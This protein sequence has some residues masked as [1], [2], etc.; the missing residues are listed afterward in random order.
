MTLPLPNGAKLPQVI[1]ELNA[2]GVRVAEIEAKIANQATKNEFYDTRLDSIAAEL[3]E[4]QSHWADIH[5]RI[6]VLEE[7]VDRLTPCP[8]ETSE[9]VPPDSDPPPDPPDPPPDP[10][11]EP[12]LFLLAEPS[13]GLSFSALT[14]FIPAAKIVLLYKSGT[15]TLETPTVVGI[16]DTDSII[17]S[18]T[19]TA[20]DEDSWHLTVQLDSKAVGSYNANISVAS[21]NQ[22]N[23]TVEVPITFTVDPAPPVDPPEEEE[24]LH[25]LAEPTS[26][27]FSGQEGQPAPANKIVLL[28][29]NGTGTL[30]T[31]QVIGITDPGGVIAGTVIS[32][33]DADSWHLTVSMK[34]TT[35]ATYNA[36]ITVQS[37]NQT[38]DP[39]VIPVTYVVAAPATTPL[40]LQ[41]STELLPITI[42]E[43]T[44][45]S[46]QT[47]GLA[48]G[49]DGALATPTASAPSESW[50]TGV[51]I[52]GSWPNWSAQLTFDTDALAD[53]LHSAT[54]DFQSA[55]ATNNPQTLTVQ[56][57][58]TNVASPGVFPYGA[59]ALPNGMLFDY[60]ENGVRLVTGSPL[61][62]SH[63]A[64][65]P[66][67]GTIR[68]VANASDWNTKAP[69]CVAGDA[70]RITAD[71][72]T[73]SPLMWNKV[74]PSGFVRVITD[75]L[76]QLDIDVP[77]NGD[78]LN[79]TSLNRI[80]LTDTT[81]YRTITA[82][83]TNAPA[84]RFGQGAC[85]LAI[86]GVQF[87]A[88]ISA[89]EGPI[90]LGTLTASQV[91][92]LPHR[93]ILDRCIGN[94]DEKMKR[95]INMNC[96]DALICGSLGINA[97]SSRPVPGTFSD[98]QGLAAWRGGLQC[99]IF[100]NAFSGESECVAFG[101]S[102]PGITNLIAGTDVALIRNHL[103]KPSSWDSDV[104]YPL[105][106][107]MIEWKGCLRF[108]YMGNVLENYKA[109]NQ[110]QHHQVVIKAETGGETWITTQ[111]LTILGNLYDDGDEGGCYNISAQGSNSL[112]H[113][114]MARITIVH[115]Y[116]R[117]QGTDSQS[118]L[119]ILCGSGAGQQIKI[120][121]LHIEHVTVG[122][123][124]TFIKF[125]IPQ[126][127]LWSNFVA[128]NIASWA[129]PTYG[130]ILINSPSPA[131]Y[132]KAALDTY[133][134][135]GGWDVKKL[136]C[137]SGG[138]SWT[139]GGSLAAAPH[140]CIQDTAA[141]MFTDPGTEDFSPKAGGPL[142]GT[143]TDGFGI[144][145]DKAWVEALTT[146]V[147]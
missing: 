6:T 40:T 35:A 70:L 19:I 18:V 33:I 25:L 85:G 55:N 7:K 83:G 12:D 126:A 82:T 14:G 54:I 73:S 140:S 53:G 95:G 141:N 114:P 89:N 30:S 97:T 47:I 118:A 37:A 122:C 128:R 119:Q 56:L 26:L 102:S 108:L 48:Q 129:V 4:H 46:P 57:T 124:D 111:D 99:L 92:H 64:L 3:L 76:A 62:F 60:D 1:K 43:G 5:A 38:N 77:F 67:T 74:I 59:A 29:K 50:I 66:I 84:I 87:K 21:S 123:R 72:S 52:T 110:G 142:D 32:V 58:V 135:V 22:T 49:G 34:S 112:P 138:P 27:S 91:S 101:G 107:N 86:T 132:N 139:Q 51:N 13:G 78:Y 42:D 125:N 88:G 103:F 104:T 96:R 131:N 8:D 81:C 31:P 133:L 28:F 20:V 146:G 93:L 90:D 79:C 143:A 63:T 65:P 15:G 130:P 80:A 120:D 69:L 105:K 71:F 121:D 44:D 136:A 10:P 9:P 115:D 36:S 147:I 2:L 39:V 24:D 41:L 98:S 61:S 106:K 45:A 116:F 17:D 11:A 144:G 94:A 16:T 109:S 113:G 137:V 134:G 117:D 127:S 75:R 23:P 145:A 68:D 100:N